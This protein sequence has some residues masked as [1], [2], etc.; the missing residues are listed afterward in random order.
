MAISSTASSISYSSSMLPCPRYMHLYFPNLNNICHF[1][2]HLTHFIRSSCNMCLS[3]LFVIFLNTFMSSTIFSTLLDIS[4]SKSFKYSQNNIG[5]NTD[6]CGTPFKP[7][8][9]LKSVFYAVDYIITYSRGF[10]LSNNL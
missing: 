10:R 5:P 4:S 9:Q 1:S 3:V 6:P 2:E 8:F 7:D